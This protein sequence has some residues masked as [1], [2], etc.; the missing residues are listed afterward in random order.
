MELNREYTKTK[1]KIKIKTTAN[2]EMDVSDA[3]AALTHKK[4]GLYTLEYQ[5]SQLLKSLGE[6]IDNPFKNEEEEKKFKEDY[7]DKIEYIKTKKSAE[8]IRENL[9]EIEKKISELKKDIAEMGNVLE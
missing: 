7:Y 2:E 6:A 3:K 8:D 1:D 4:G 5:K 9:K